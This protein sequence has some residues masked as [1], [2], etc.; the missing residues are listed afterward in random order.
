[1]PG[2][3][4]KWIA[5]VLLLAAMGIVVGVWRSSRPRRNILVVTLDTTRADRL[6]CYGYHPGQTEVLDQLAA[7]GVVFE[8]CYAP[9]PLTLP[10]HASMFTGLLPPEHG[11]RTN[12]RGRLPE[13]VPT[14]AA[15]LSEWG[16][17]TGAFVGSFV[18]D[19]LF[20]LDRG[21]EQYDDDMTGAAP[22][23]HGIHQCRAGE[24]VT[25]DALNWLEQNANRPF[26]C[27][28][29]LYDPHKPYDPHRDLFGDR[30]QE[31]PYDGEIAY[32]DSQVG[33]LL[34]FLRQR[35]LLKSTLVVIAGDHG[36]SLGEHDEETHGYLVYNATL[37]VP[38]IIAG[39]EVA[40]GRRVSDMVRLVDLSPTILDWSGLPGDNS[41]SGRSLLPA[42]RGASLE[43]LSCYSESDEPYLDHGWSPLRSLIAGHWKFIQTTQPELYNL[44]DDPRELVNL[45]RQ[46]PARAKD[47]DATLGELI[48]SLTLRQGVDVRLSQE[49]HRALASLGYVGG[50]H[51]KSGPAA[52]AATL[53]DVKE[54]MRPNQAVQ[55]A[56]DLLEERG[57][58][59]AVTAL[60]QV[61]QDYPDYL[62]ARC[63]LAE[64]QTT[65]GRP[66]EAIRLSE[67]LI[68]EAPHLRDAWFHLGNAKSALGRYSEALEDYQKAVSLDADT[69][70]LH[71][72]MG[73]ALIRL[74][75]FEEAR[76]RLEES[77]KLDPGYSLAHVGL[78]I[79]FTALREPDLA[80]EQYERALYFDSRNVEAH[81]NLA[82][83]LASIGMVDEAESH[84]RTAVQL[85]PSN[86]ETHFNLGLLLLRRN[87]PAE[88]VESLEQAVRLNPQH[89]AAAKTLEQIRARR[90]RP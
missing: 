37:H 44:A 72:N 19:S 27:W 32:V 88:S 90:V 36:E 55:Q 69:S 84:F 45:I 89:I 34:D 75:R 17:R 4:S 13:E 87:R 38:L 80:R 67:E 22:A 78:G 42:L 8:R 68:H 7:Q 73:M 82:A 15:R 61:V 21:F 70:G 2:R 9:I 41:L 39:P 60:E 18:L 58:S 31:H 26:F 77:L 86:A 3:R 12:G 49:Q 53:P 47:M 66:E 85:A 81:S 51:A 23:A 11:L 35:R 54:M 64:A 59:A 57:A 79:L 6:G 76:V 24:R 43:E 52:Q 20:G 74:G 33:R 63:A 28:V 48:A 40:G 65:A 1:M 5:T 25:S 29:H 56:R 14:L 16:Y 50:G 62:P 30:F 83:L 10:S 46:E 71:Y